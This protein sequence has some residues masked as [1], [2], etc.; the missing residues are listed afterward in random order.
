M[1]ARSHKEHYPPLGVET[2]QIF[3][4]TEKGGRMPS[5]R[6]FEGF[7]GLLITGSMYDAHGN[8]QWILDLLHLLE[9]K[10]DARHCVN[11][12]QNYGPRNP[13]STSRV[14]VSATS[15]SPVCWVQKSPTR[16]R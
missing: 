10:S 2:G 14:C 15:S 7:D 6:D 5:Y 3:V 1:L 8:N 13:T 16:P 9:G 11:A 4:V 12:W